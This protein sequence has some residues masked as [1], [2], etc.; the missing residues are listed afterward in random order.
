MTTTTRIT[1]ITTLTL[2]L[3]SSPQAA[4]STET[5][6]VGQPPD[7]S[8]RASDSSVILETQTYQEISPP[9]DSP[10]TTDT[11]G[12]AGAPAENEATDSADSAPAV[13]Y[14]DETTQQAPAPGACT[15]WDP[16]TDDKPPV[17]IC[18]ALPQPDDSA[19]DDPA[20][21]EPASAPPAP[22]PLTVTARDVATAIADGSGLTRQPPGPTVLITKPL[23]VYTNP[24]PP[25]PDHHHRH[26]HC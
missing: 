13:A 26:Y 15:V 2:I 24:A 23:I 5:P 6:S 9:A 12:Q 4:G 1:L 11:P 10:R 17:A 18:T 3:G 20:P 21:A 19:P 8:G 16:L 14:A 25:E 22:R 7:L